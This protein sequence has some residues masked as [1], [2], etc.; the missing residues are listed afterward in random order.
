MES[1]EEIEKALGRLVP[2]ALSEQGLRSMEEMIEG[3]AA[4]TVIT[5]EL[6]EK[7][8]AIR[9]WAAGIG[10]AAAAVVAAFSLSHGPT[11]LSTGLADVL[12]DGLPSGEEIVLIDESEEVEDA[13][14]EDWMSEED[15]VPHRA[16]RFRVTNHER[17]RDVRTGYEVVVSR[18]REEVRLM[19]VTSF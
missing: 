4:G 7:S 14:P 10:A 5:P 13:V 3:L 8:S 9:W 15:G 16:W 11:V 18:P 17:V 2:S 6:P 19:P 12:P 1:P